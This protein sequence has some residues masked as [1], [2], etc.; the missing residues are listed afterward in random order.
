MSINVNIHTTRAPDAIRAH[1]N[2]SYGA[3][4]HIEIADSVGGLPCDIAIFTG[5]L[6]LADALA[7]AING[8]MERFAKP[9][10][11]EATGEIS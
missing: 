8:V 3:P 9:V 4:L 11:I 2:D 10:P 7:E 6:A 5:S 1:T